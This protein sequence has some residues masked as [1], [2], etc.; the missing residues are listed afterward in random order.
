MM[1]IYLRLKFVCFFT[2][3]G[4]SAFAQMV[5]PTLELPAANDTF[6][7]AS[8]LLQTSNHGDAIIEFEID[9]V[10]DFSSPAMQSVLS[11][12]NNWGDKEQGRVTFLQYNTK[13]YL[14]AR[15]AMDG[16]TSDW[17]STRAFRTTAYPILI[18]P[19]NNTAN[20]VSAFAWNDAG[21]LTYYLQVDTTA[22][23]SSPFAHTINIAD[24]AFAKYGSI[25]AAPEKLLYGKKHYWRVKAFHHT[26][27]SLWSPVWSFSLPEKTTLKSPAT[28][29]T[30]QN[31]NINLEWNGLWDAQFYQL[32]YDTLADFSSVVR[33]DTLV[34]GPNTTKTTVDNLYF[35]RKYY[36]HVRAI[37]AKD[38]SAWSEAWNFETIEKLT[39][40]YP[41]DNKTGISLADVLSWN[42][43]GS[44]TH[45]QA[46]TDSSESFNS[47]QLFDTV[48]TSNSVQ[49]Q[50]RM[51]A[52][53]YFWRSRIVN[54]NDSSQWSEVRKFTTIARETAQNLIPT[55]NTTNLSINSDFTV[56]NVMAG[57]H[58]AIEIDTTVNFNSPL[59]IR[60]T[61]RFAESERY[62]RKNI[63]G[64]RFAQKY[65]WRN[66]NFNN[67]D[68]TNWSPLYTFTTTAKPMLE[69]PYNNQARQ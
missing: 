65:Y 41:A 2:F 14:R 34:K 37:Y 29:I 23:F 50:N 11:F 1:R 53:T 42:R 21:S 46:Q 52:T 66:K 59:L 63:K 24:T 31:D 20:G 69:F 68:S 60:D 54:K 64:L 49:L 44:G 22:D 45:Y 47:P 57:N 67:N 4:L 33:K 6:V 51:Y 36:W 62:P 25:Y 48:T 7:S 61:L 55:N 43:I 39:L 26:D 12:S 13:Y 18:N 56:V 30:N 9:S 58:A 3:I 35:G 17:T 38:T 40:T 19:K 16:D 8:S 10:A 5:P 32:Q 27:T 15:S 28:N